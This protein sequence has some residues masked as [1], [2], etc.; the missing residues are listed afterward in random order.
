MATK[1]ATRTEGCHRGSEVATDHPSEELRDLFRTCIEV[2]RAQAGMLRVVKAEIA[3]RAQELLQAELKSGSED[4]H[5]ECASF[6]VES[7]AEELW[8]LC[9]DMEELLVDIAGDGPSAP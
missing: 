1:Q 6:L 7:G 9:Q 8:E 5:R 3:D 4:L 2:V